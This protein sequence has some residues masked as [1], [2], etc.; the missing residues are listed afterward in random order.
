MLKKTPC[1]HLKNLISASVN[2]TQCL[3]ET[4]MIVT[5]K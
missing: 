5:Y 4:I 2:F 1:T 3:I